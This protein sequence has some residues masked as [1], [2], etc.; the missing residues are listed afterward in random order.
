ML[1]L[2]FLSQLPFRWASPTRLV[3]GLNSSTSAKHHYSR[4]GR[5]GGC[6]RP[7]V[8]AAILKQI[9]RIRL[10]ATRNGGGQRSKIGQPEGERSGGMKGLPT[11]SQKAR[12]D[13]A[14]GFLSSPRQN[15]VW[16]RQATSPRGF[17]E[18]RFAEI[19]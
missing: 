6:G 16:K 19:K 15:C 13:A 1:S 7:S 3:T 5:S 18:K 12:K 9:P 8:H 4:S 10:S 2:R 17:L 11:L 14:P